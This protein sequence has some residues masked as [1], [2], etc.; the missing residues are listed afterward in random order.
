M[1][2]TMKSDVAVNAR[3][4][5]I[6]R[7]ML[8]DGKSI[9][10]YIN[11]K[12]LNVVV[13][14]PKRRKYLIFIANSFSRSSSVAILSKRKNRVETSSICMYIKMR[15]IFSPVRSMEK[16]RFAHSLRNRMI[17]MRIKFTS[18]VI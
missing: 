6:N 15:Y 17:I 3:K 2:T 11:R 5:A 18:N 1:K 4:S 12:S 16:F 8:L 7:L 10:T 9:Y 13:Y 14:T